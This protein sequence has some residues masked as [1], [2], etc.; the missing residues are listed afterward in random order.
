MLKSIFYFLL[1][2]LINTNIILSHETISQKNII[3]LSSPS[4]AISI[5][6]QIK[7]NK[8]AFISIEKNGK[9]L[10][11]VEDL[12]FFTEDDNSEKSLTINGNLKQRSHK[13]TYQL[14]GN[15]DVAINHYNEIIVP[16]I[17]GTFPYN[18]VL[19]AYDDGFAL[20]YIFN[21]C[22]NK[23]IKRENTSWNI[24]PESVSYW[25]E[26]HRGHERLH[27]E[28]LFEHIADSSLTAMPFTI[29]HKDHYLS[30]SEAD[31]R[32]FP[33]LSF[34][35]INK[36]LSAHFASSPEG[37]NLDDTGKSPWRCVIIAEDLTTLVN[38]DL[39]MNL[40]EPP[41]QDFS[42]DWVE[43][44]RVLWHWWSIGD[45]VLEDQKNWYQAAERLSWE[46]YL[47]DDGWRKW[48]EGDKDQWQ[49]LKEVID[50][51]LSIGV[52]TIIWVD[53]KEMLN[54][55][56]LTT[57]LDRVK[58]SGAAGIKIDFIPEPT[59]GIIKWYQLALKETAERELLCNFHGCV[60]PSGLRRTWPHELTREAIRGH[61]WHISR[62]NR[63]MPMNQDAILPF[64]R[65]LAGPADYTPTV[66]NKDEL[67]GYSWSHELAQAII[68][69][70]P[71]T[72]FADSYEYYL[73]NPSEDLL[74]DIPVYWDETLVIP[75]SKIG[76]VVGYARR[77]GDEWW[78]G[79]IN[80]EVSKN[81][82]IKLDFLNQKSCATILS[83]SKLS[84]SS[85]YRTGKIVSPENIFSISLNS[86]GGFVARFKP[87]NNSK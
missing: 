30:F 47:I 26:Y 67:L 36:G 87:V 19:R 41:A 1:G 70:S 10:T 63:V 68:Y 46:Y 50:Y 35:K 25:A 33:D 22:N 44:G 7:N 79:I 81:I 15:H 76:D 43:P 52:K 85:F 73:D 53:S 13:E 32:F 3:E 49:C 16:V 42:F 45:P 80:S 20:R 17:E 58:E 34:Q 5:T 4:K 84:E 86:G 64:T 72:H 57:Y 65:L 39:I 62:Y 54:Y 59:Q 11:R 61:E 75:C 37:F 82:Q 83:D 31:N 6:L 9:I 74:R 48:R 77:K 28:T 60:K 18:L 38:S 24:S 12:G 23:I 27:N 14:Y 66:F 51:G 71:L 78:L 56:K 2:I 21:N 29:K 55:E 40:C 69:L 8:K